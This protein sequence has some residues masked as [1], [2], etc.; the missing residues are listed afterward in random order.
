MQPGL[1]L[2]GTSPSA[3]VTTETAAR[4]SAFPGADEGRRAAE[5]V[6]SAPQGA[7]ACDDTGAGRGDMLAI[8]RTLPRHRAGRP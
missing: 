1:F 6:R 2:T 5:P 3:G 7:K 4:C 8:S